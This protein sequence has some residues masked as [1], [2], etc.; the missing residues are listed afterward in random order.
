KNLES[1]KNRK[2]QTRCIQ[3]AKEILNE[4]PIT[5]YRPSFLN[6]L[7]I[8]AFFQKYRIALEVQVA[9]HR[10]HSISRYKDVKKLKDIVNHDRQKKCICQDNGIFLLEVWYDQKPE[11]VIPKRIQIIKEFVNQAFNHNTYL[12]YYKKKLST[13]SFNLALRHPECGKTFAYKFL[14]FRLREGNLSDSKTEHRRYS[15]ELDTITEYL[16]DSSPSSTTLSNAVWQ[17]ER[18]AF[19]LVSIML[20]GEHYVSGPNDRSSKKVKD[21]W[22]LHEAIQ[23]ENRFY[24]EKSRLRQK[25]KLNDLKDQISVE[26]VQHVLSTTKETFSQ[27]LE[28]QKTI[29]KQHLLGETNAGSIIGQKRNRDSGFPSNKEHELDSDDQEEK[30]QQSSQQKRKCTEPVVDAENKLF[31]GSKNNLDGGNESVSSLSD[32]EIVPNCPAIINDVIGLEL[33]PLPRKE[34]L[35]HI[36]LLKPKQH[37]L[38]IVE[39][40]GDELL[41][42]MHEN[43]VQRLT[44]QETEYIS[45]LHLFDVK[46]FYALV[47]ATTPTTEGSTRDDAVSELQRTIL[48]AIRNIIEKVPRLTLKSPVGEEYYRSNKEAV[49]SKAR[50]PVSRAKQPDA[51]INEIDQLSW[52]LSKGHGEA[53]VQEEMNNFYLLCT[54]LIWIAIFNKDAIDFYNMNCILGF[55]VVGELPTGIITFYLTTL[56]CDALYVM[57]EVGHVDVPMSLEQVSAFLTSLD[58]LLIILNA[59]WSNCIMST[60]KKKPSRRS[61]LATPSFKEMVSKNQNSVDLR[62]NLM[63]SAK[64]DFDKMIREAFVEYEARIE[65]ERQNEMTSNVVTPAKADNYNDVYFD[66]EDLKEEEGE[67]SKVKS[68]DDSDS[69]NSEEEMP[70]DSDDDGYDK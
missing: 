39:V 59:Y 51:I 23:S 8:D 53:K 58:T 9:Q 62:R 11:I 50:K 14:E 56:L 6:G 64:D 31:L 54:D 68:D 28:L 1:K 43:I 40:F 32:T 47:L 36:L 22:E 4:E 29:I 37:C 10:L 20:V 3:I 19:L 13:F 60:E 57:V 45:S 18:T 44:K 63:V 34:L 66:E 21:F 7:E 61:T 25:D 12:I 26:Q 55:Q 70:D 48:K 2:F 5:E 17:W 41:V 33:G 16:S 67:S 27:N 15:E 65:K 24:E 38:L 52:S 69:S 30:Y 46:K 35:S 49:E 42:T